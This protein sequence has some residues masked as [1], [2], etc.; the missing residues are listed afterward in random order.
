MH[1]CC[2][3]GQ[4]SIRNY[5]L[6]GFLPVPGGPWM[7]AGTH[8][9]EQGPPLSF[10]GDSRELLNSAGSERLL[11]VKQLLWVSKVG[12]FAPTALP[13]FP[14]AHSELCYVAPILVLQMIKFGLTAAG[15][16]MF[17]RIFWPMLH[18]ISFGTY[19]W[20]RQNPYWRSQFCLFGGRIIF[21]ICLWWKVTMHNSPNKGKSHP[22][23][24]ALWD[25]YN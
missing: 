2:L 3:T 23:E 9:T 14:R 12:S 21:L 8:H 19:F 22:N 20:K 7:D 18:S 24:P 16:P 1:G 13:L 17:N 6:A 5:K 25:C 10:W 15:K 4:Q 11:A